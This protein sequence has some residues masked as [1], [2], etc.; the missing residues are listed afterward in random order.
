M[1][2]KKSA[3][4]GGQPFPP[5]DSRTI[6]VDADSL[7]RL[8]NEVGEV[9]SYKLTTL[10]K[11]GDSLIQTGNAP[12]YQGNRITLCTCMHWHRTWP[13]IKKGTWVAGFSGNPNN[14][15]F[16]LM[17]IEAIAHN[18]AELW[19][20]G[21][22]PDVKA[23]SAC[24]DIFGDAY[25]PRFLKTPGDPHDPQSYEKPIKH[26]KHHKHPHDDE[27]H[28]DIRYWTQDKN[29]KRK[30]TMKPRPHKLL[31]GDPGKSFVWEHPKYR[32]KGKHPRM[33]FPSLTSFISH[34]VPL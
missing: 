1:S 25:V 30:R 12:N 21:L 2:C 6:I 13:R 24:K 9:F 11:S 20:S 3:T 18:F 23:K 10:K 31:I 27:W 16:Y 5:S 8:R 28:K 15:L 32:H 22:L 4:Y 29:R 14:E 19:T 34:L 7:V 17:K 26:H 33:K